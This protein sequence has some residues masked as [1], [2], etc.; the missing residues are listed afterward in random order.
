MVQVAL[1][2]ATPTGLMGLVPIMGLAY[3]GVFGLSPAIVGDRFGTRHFGINYGLAA[4]AP[5]LGS[6]IFSTLVAG[7][8]ADREG[9]R[10]G[11]VVIAKDGEEGVQCVG[12]DCYRFSHVTFVA[13]LALATLACVCLWLHS[14]R[15]PQPASSKA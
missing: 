3:G 8:L 12:R 15:T 14:R 13:V 9:R 4:T 10:H 5:A 7:K 6:L 11:I 2:F 1:C